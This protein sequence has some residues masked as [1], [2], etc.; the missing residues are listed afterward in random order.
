MS[1]TVVLHGAHHWRSASRP[2]T[3]LQPLWPPVGPPCGITG[4]SSPMFIDVHRCP[5]WLVYDSCCSLDVTIW[6]EFEHRCNKKNQDS[7][8]LGTVK[9]GL[10]VHGTSTFIFNAVSCDVSCDLVIDLPT[11]KHARERLGILR[12]GMSFPKTAKLTCESKFWIRNNIVELY[13]IHNEFSRR[14]WRFWPWKLQRNGWCH[15]CPQSFSRCTRRSDRSLPWCWFLEQ[16]LHRAVTGHIAP[17]LF[18]LHIMA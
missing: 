2:S 15:E 10:G 11:I 7:L 1:C 8:N 14:F 4:R 13:T 16:V 12:A 6:I 17:I 3:R 9:V 18:L 5:L